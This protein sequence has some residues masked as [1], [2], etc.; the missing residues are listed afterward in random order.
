MLYKNNKKK[1]M[2]KTLL[3]ILQ[4]GILISVILTLFCV[5]LRPADAATVTENVEVLTIDE[6]DLEKICTEAGGKC[7]FSNDQI[8]LGVSLP[9]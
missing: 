2:N 7:I 1:R 3:K 6:V 5:A 4:S 8:L 9:C